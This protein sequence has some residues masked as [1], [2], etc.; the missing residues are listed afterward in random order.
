M[1]PKW[2]LGYHQCRWSYDSS[3]KVLKVFSRHR[4][5]SVYICFHLEKLLM[6]CFS[7]SSP[8]S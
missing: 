3:E 2:A 5:F 1:P 7:G 8:Y 4:K 6:Y